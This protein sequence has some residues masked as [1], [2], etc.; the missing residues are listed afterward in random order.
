MT[1][2][3]AMIMNTPRPAASIRYSGQWRR[4]ASIRKPSFPRKRE[5]RNG[6]TVTLAPG[7]PL[8]RGRRFWFVMF[9]APGPEFRIQR[10]PA[11]DKQGDAVDVIALIGREPDR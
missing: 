10:H 2:T 4:R 5:S 11:V 7:P 1:Q 6:K 9:S 3:P 8:S